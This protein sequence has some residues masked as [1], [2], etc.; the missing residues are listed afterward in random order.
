MATYTLKQ[1]SEKTGLTA[2]TIRYYMSQGLLPGAVGKG[3]RA[4]YTRDHLDRLNEI[5]EGKTR[6]LDLSDLRPT[7]GWGFPVVIPSETWTHYKLGPGVILTVR[8]DV[9]PRKI[10]RYVKAFHRD[11]KE[12]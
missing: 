9:R 2:R 3:K 8:D 5:K 1:L 10:R 11:L 4:Y 7:C 6:G 12:Q